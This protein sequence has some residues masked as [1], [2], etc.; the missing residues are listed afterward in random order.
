MK[1]HIKLHHYGRFT[2]PPKREF[3]NEMI[4][5][6][7]TANLATITT[8]KLKF[9]LTNNLG[10]DANSTTFL[11]VKKPGSNLDN[12]LVQIDDVLQ[13]RDAI[14][15]YTCVH[16]RLHVYVSRVDLSPLVVEE[17]H[18]DNTMK[19]ETQGKPSCSKRLFD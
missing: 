4:A 15:M 9:V 12:G 1:I 16:N 11:Y 19:I 5:T 13:E 18:N 2:T 8:D 3:V 6:L 17:G 14:H 7:E 10:Y